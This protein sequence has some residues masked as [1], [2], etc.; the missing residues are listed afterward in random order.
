M[1]GFIGCD[2]DLDAGAV[3]VTGKHLEVKVVVIAPATEEQARESAERLGHELVVVEGER[4]YEVEFTTLPVGS[5][6]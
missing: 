1:R 5:E 6:N 3:I 4:F 2:A